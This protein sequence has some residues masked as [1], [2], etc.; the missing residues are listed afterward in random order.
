VDHLSQSDLQLRDGM[1]AIA[2]G[3]FWMGS[4]DLYPEERPAREVA[5]DPFLIDPTPVTNRMFAEFVAATGYVT[6]AEKA[7]DLADYPGADPAMLQPGSAI[8][9]PPP[10]PVDLGQPMRW[11]QFAFGADWRH[12]YGAGSDVAALPDHPVVHIAYEDAEAYATWAGK[13]LPTEAEWEMAARGGLDRKPYAWGS[14][15]EPDGQILANY[16]QG[17]FP[18]EHRRAPGFPRTTAVGSYPENGFGLFDMIGNVWEWTA[19]WYGEGPPNPRQCCVPRNPRGVSE[20]A[21]KGHPCERFGRKVLKG[22][23]HLCADNYC[24]RYR[25]AARLAQPIDSPTCHIGF[26][27]ARSALKD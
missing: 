13:R 17:R 21:S 7:P 6:F 23:S 15:L 8:F 1:R 26:R 14:E 27:C 5:V 9:V 3:H 24:Q 20:A 2:G 18:T 4:D 12:P 22:G 11:W 25:P 19:D 10:P 16:W